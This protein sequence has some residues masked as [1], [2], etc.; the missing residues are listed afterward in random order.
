MYNTYSKIFDMWKILIP[1]VTYNIT[2]KMKTLK[3][4]ANGSTALIT[5]KILTGGGSQL[6]T[7]TIVCLSSHASK[8][9]VKLLPNDSIHAV[10]STENI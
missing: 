2:Y 1:W 8:L 9:Q 6:D 7:K 3:L 10:Q 5:Q 4:P